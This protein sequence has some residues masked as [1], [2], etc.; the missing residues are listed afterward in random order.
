MTTNFQ[1]ALTDKHISELYTIMIIS[2]K[3]SR[4]T[5]KINQCR[6]KHNL[7]QYMLEQMKDIVQYT[8]IITKIEDMIRDLIAQLNVDLY[9]DDTTKFE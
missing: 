9:S 4:F 1:C 6:S 7:I 3:W 2:K 5:E 8:V